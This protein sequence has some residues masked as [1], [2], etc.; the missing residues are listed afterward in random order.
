MGEGLLGEGVVGDEG[1][2]VA[3]GLK[4]GGKIVVRG[5]GGDELVALHGALG[6]EGDGGLELG[7]GFGWA[8]VVFEPAAVEGVGGVVLGGEGDGAEEVLLG[9][10][11]GA[12]VAR[13]GVGEGAFDDAE[14]DLKSGVVG[15]E[16]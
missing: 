7:D 5:I 10:G 15:H 16:G 12:G 2:G 4:G 13:G 3:S 1:E 9:E 14:V 11:G 8:A 6:V